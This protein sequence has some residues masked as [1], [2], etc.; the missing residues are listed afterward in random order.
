MSTSLL[1]HAFGVRGY[2]YVSTDYS[3]RAR[4]GHH[5]PQRETSAVIL[6]GGGSQETAC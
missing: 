1:Y 3:Q 2:C 4:A 5:W 6:L